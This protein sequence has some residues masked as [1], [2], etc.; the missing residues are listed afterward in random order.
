MPILLLVILWPSIVGVQ[1]VEQ[2]R[3]GI[4]ALEDSQ[5]RINYLRDN[6]ELIDR[7]RL[8]FLY[9]PVMMIL[10]YFM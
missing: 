1:Q 10:C 2:A 4:D 9:N 5:M 6:F 8:P 7:Y 3:A